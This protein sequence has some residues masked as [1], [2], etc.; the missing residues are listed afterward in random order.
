M[1]TVAAAL[2]ARARREIQHHFFAADAV[3]PGRA[4]AFEPERGIERSQFERMRDRGIIR[5]EAPGHYWLN[6]I[7]YDIDLGR[8]HRNLRNVLLAIIAV[9]LVMLALGAFETTRPATSPALTH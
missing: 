7:D 8:R 9:L 3:R 5:E 6:V 4:I 2:I 1:A